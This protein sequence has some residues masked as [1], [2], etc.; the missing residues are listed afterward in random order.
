MPTPYVHAF[1]QGHI[2]NLDIRNRLCNSPAIP[3]FSRRN[4]SITE[5]ECD[6]YEE[7]AQGGYGLVFV[8]ACAVNATTARSYTNQ[9][10]LHDDTFVPGWRRLSEAIHKHGAKCGVQIY[11]P[12][13][14]NHPKYCGPGSVPEAPSVVPCPLES[15]I[16]GYQLVEMSK[17]RIA[18]VSQEFASASRR[19]KE[20]G[21][22][23]VEI[24][25]GHGY[26]FSQFFSK[27]T[28]RR[29]DEYG[30]DFAGRTRFVRET[31]EAIRQ[32]VGPNFPIGIRISAEDLVEDGTTIE[33]SIEY[34]RFLETLGIAY[35]SVSVG[36][37]TFPGLYL[38][39]LGSYSS[40]GHM[41]P[42]AGAIKQQVK[43]PILQ[44]GGF[45]H[46]GQAEE[47]LASGTADF[48]I[49][50]RASIADPHIVR[51]TLEGREDEIRPC[52]RCNNGCIDRLW[53][54]RDITCT[55]NPELGREREFREKI[56]RG[57]SRSKRVMVVGGGP[58]GL[59]CAKYAALRGHKVTV[60]EKGAE[61][62]GQ[63]KY[64]CRSPGRENWSELT[65][66]YSRE[67][68]KLGVEIR[69]NCEVSLESVREVGPDAVVVATGSRFRCQPIAGL[70][71]AD[72]RLVEN[73]VMCHDV[74]A[75]NEK[76]GE[77]VVVVG[78]NMM[79]VLM[80][81][82][83]SEQGKDVIIIEALPTLNQDMDG[84]VNW[85]G[86]LLSD[87]EER[88][89]KIMT[90]S[91]VR[92]VRAGGVIVEAAGEI[93]PME[94][95]RPLITVDTEEFVPCDSVVVGTARAARSELFEGLVGQVPE[96]YIVGDAV[97]PR[98]AYSAVGE[99][100]SLGLEL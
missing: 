14:Q 42:F 25:G 57:A 71:R 98:W 53:A 81:R 19:V 2:G 93:P 49:M 12:G 59:A 34:A 22:D 64:A 10:G 66:Y 75:E 73:V 44:Y 74:A 30:G 29:N 37:Y 47:V 95:V 68:E 21:F 54:M 100:A 40:S 31:L 79:G 90:H 92:E 60:F 24:H 72:G 86:Y 33:E 38:M 58:A 15:A 3:N 62:G 88:G 82:L 77:R 28:N 32:Q 69:L 63:I 13:R 11:H 41:A 39:L 18:D 87:L 61:L 50:N 52:L 78:G 4:G 36:Q 96:L 27:E 65:T 20:A 16:P 80:A 23:L 17:Q 35:I 55:M 76:V 97:K 8:S 89:I 45:T 83:L 46:V 1:S 94:K 85:F 91:V 70:R 99:G 48:V 5:R 6:Y 7:K 67:I 9:P 56:R 84:P 43:V 26:L 51:K